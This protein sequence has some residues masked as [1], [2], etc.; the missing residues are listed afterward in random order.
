M[1]AG[2]DCP[3]HLVQTHCRKRG[4]T[5]RVI[6]NSVRAYVLLAARG[7]T[8][9]GAD[10]EDA[11][12]FASVAGSRGMQVLAAQVIAR[13]QGQNGTEKARRTAVHEAISSGLEE[14]A[15]AHPNEVCFLQ[16]Q[17]TSEIPMSFVLYGCSGDVQRQCP[18]GIQAKELMEEVLELMQ[19][20]EG[21]RAV[22]AGVFTNK[23]G[24]IVFPDIDTGGP[25]ATEMKRALLTDNRTMAWLTDKEGIVSVPPLPA[26]FRDEHEV[27]KAGPLPP[28]AFDTHGSTRQ[29]YSLFASVAAA[30][31][32]LPPPG[33]FAS[34]EAC[35]VA[36]AAVKGSK[37]QQLG[38]SDENLAAI[39]PLTALCPPVTQYLQRVV[40]DF[41]VRSITLHAHCTHLSCKHWHSRCKGAL[42]NSGSVHMHGM[43]MQWPS[44]SCNQ[45]TTNR[46]PW[47]ARVA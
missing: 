16:C 12:P 30:A 21:S 36:W 47:L 28:P 43:Q 38:L 20:A 23:E 33:M 7:C 45:R 1:P 25:A 39:S 2:Y 31:V 19:R 4:S 11:T 26:D 3:P 44:L 40:T 8:T 35:D 24:S 15:D 29:G 13:V 5:N 14:I 22:E 46:V 6:I 37:V 18:S 32:L 17:C 34:V 10:G 27:P 42:S 9:P 41:T